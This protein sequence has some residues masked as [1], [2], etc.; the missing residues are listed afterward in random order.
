MVAP[1]AA[2]IFRRVT[3]QESRD[4]HV[5]YTTMSSAPSANAWHVRSRRQMDEGGIF[6]VC[7]ACSV[8]RIAVNHRNACVDSMKWQQDFCWTSA[9]W[10]FGQFAATWPESAPVLDILRKIL[11]DDLLVL[12]CL[13]EVLGL[14][15][16]FLNVWGKTLVLVSLFMG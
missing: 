9:E 14:L 12:A 16:P 10:S 7:V 2:I 13:L 3:S 5:V 11:R 1:D 15:W 6:E 4:H 8:G